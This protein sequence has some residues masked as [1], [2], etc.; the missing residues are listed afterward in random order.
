MRTAAGWL[1]RTDSKTAFLGSI[2]SDK[3][4]PKDVRSVALDKLLVAIRDEARELGFKMLVGSPSVPA[5]IDR[6]ER[7]GFALVRNCAFA[8]GG[9]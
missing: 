7:H 2:I 8:S 1:Y 4:A 6:F 9:L 5:L 3:D